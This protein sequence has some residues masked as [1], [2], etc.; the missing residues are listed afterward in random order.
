MSNQHIVF[1]SLNF[2][3]VDVEYDLQLLDDNMEKLQ[4]RLAHLENHLLPSFTEIM[5]T[6]FEE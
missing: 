5:A 3:K 2:T 6:G 1:Q 4:Q